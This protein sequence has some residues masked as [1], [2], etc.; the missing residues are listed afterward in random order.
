MG[1][2]ICVNQLDLTSIDPADIQHF[3]KLRITF[4]LSQLPYGGTATPRSPLPTKKLMP[5]SPILQIGDRS[6]TTEQVLPLI[7]KYRLVPHLAREILIEEAI[8]D[9]EVT[10]AEYLAGCERFYQQQRFATDLDLDLWL[11]QQRWEREDLVELINKDLRLRKFKL[12]KWE[13]QLESHFCQRKSQL[14]RV[15]FSLIRIQEVEIAE[16]LYFRLVAQEA[17]FSELAPL[18]SSG[19]EAK[20]KGITGPVPLGS[21]DPILADAL[22]TLQPGEVLPPTQ[23]GGWWVVV[24]LETILPAQLDA[25]LRQYLTEELFNH[26]IA[27]AVQQLLATPLNPPPQL[28]AEN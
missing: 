16:E 9:Y 27:A 21:L 24:Q 22:R 1:S 17:T 28:A 19:I 20:T 6:L 8:Q 2:R 18:Y 3:P 7:A 14:D 15:V 5:P 13:H 26:W 25:E 11:Q 10:A 12:D 23:I 4:F